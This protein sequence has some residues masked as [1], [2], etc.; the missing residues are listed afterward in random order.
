MTRQTSPIVDFKAKDNLLYNIA[1]VHDYIVYNFFSS[2]SE[3]NDNSANWS[4]LKIAIDRASCLKT[5]DANIENSI[6][7]VKVIGIMNIFGPASAVLDKDV[8]CEYARLAMNID[9]TDELIKLLEKHQVIRYAKYKSRY[10]LFEGT[11]VDIEA[12][13]FEAA[14]EC[15][16]PEVVAS[17]LNDYF[18]FRVQL[19]NAHYFRTGTPRY[20]QYLL[21]GTPAE[22]VPY[23]ETDGYV[24]LI[25]PESLDN[26]RVKDLCLAVSNQAILYCVFH[27][28]ESI[29][30]HLYEIDKL[31]WVRDYYVADDNDKVALREIAKLI[32][33][34]KALLNQAILGSLFSDD[35]EWIFNGELLDEIHSSKDLAKY[36]S[37][38]CDTIYCATPVYKFEL[39]NKFKPT[40]NMSLARLS[41]LQA[42][43]EHSGEIDCG[44][45]EDKF[46]PEKSLYLTLLKNTGIHT[47][48]GL[49]APVE[50]SF[51]PLWEASEAFLKST[52]EKPRKLTELKKL[53]ESAPFRLKDGLIDCWIPA[54]LI[55]KKDDYA[56]YSEGRYV[57]YINKEA[58]DLI[59]K[60]PASITVKAFDVDGVKSRF[61]D[62]YR[63]AINLNAAE[64]SSNS[65][66]ETIRPFLSFYK[67]LNNYAKRTK[68]I[69]PNARRFRDVIANATDPEKTFFEVLPEEL[70]FKDIVLS[71]N[72]EC[73]ESFVNVIQAAILDLRGCY[74]EL[75]GTIEQVITKKLGLN[76]DFA[77]YHPVI[78][79]RYKS[80]KTELMPVNLRNFQARLIGIYQDKKTWIESVSY[81]A[82]NRPLSDIKDTDK[83]ILFNALR[84]MLFQLDDYVEMHKSDNDSIVRLHITQNS[85]KPFTAQ[86]LVPDTMNEELSELES[87]IEA[88]MSDNESLNVAALIKLLKKKVK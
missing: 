10:I 11:D 14:K 53:L 34:E 40:G 33:H 57:P 77:E 2:L 54:F 15:K 81:V 28:T 60:T 67:R 31:G 36:L 39:I 56:L 17:R 44:F 83:P 62:K 46:P 1:D 65:F 51:I 20:F 18:E 5:T 69:S 63:E 79:Q 52:V 25:F 59:L 85:G 4:A 75:I 21:T 58:L 88:L 24:N 42:L 49:G 43:L 76:G 22:S 84:D 12:G 45:P 13:L 37:R 16:K 86:V 32:E 78:R 30:A 47:S 55:I 61:F 6:A 80:M 72:P 71:Q 38:I 82:L 74:D 48:D 87:K 41:F 26:D 66:I 27:N 68:D 23:S 50:E 35:V 3:V 9:N 19:A 8:L 64:L 7:L 73:I 29:T 70:G